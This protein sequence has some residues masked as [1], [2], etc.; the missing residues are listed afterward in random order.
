MIATIKIFS[1]GAG[2]TQ[3]FDCLKLGDYHNIDTIFLCPEHQGDLVCQLYADAPVCEIA[4][5]SLELDVSSP[6]YEFLLH[7]LFGGCR[8]LA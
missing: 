8:V 4:A 7:L 5:L 2:T 6:Q 3:L 1:Y